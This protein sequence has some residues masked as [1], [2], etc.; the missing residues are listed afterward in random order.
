MG[1][2]I[3]VLSGEMG[4]PKPEN[5]ARSLRLQPAGKSSPSRPLAETK[6]PTGGFWMLE[7]ANLDRAILSRVS[8]LG[9]VD[10][11]NLPLSR[12]SHPKLPQMMVKMFVH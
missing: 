1:R 6:P 5:S 3:D 10:Q 2:A 11:R 12:R 8:F 9:A 7:A 4:G